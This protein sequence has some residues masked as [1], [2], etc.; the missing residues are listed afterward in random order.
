MEIND[1]A[2][3]I[4]KISIRNDNRESIS[5]WV[6]F[7]IHLDDVKDYET[8]RF[9]QEDGIF[10]SHQSFDGDYFVYMPNNLN[11]ITTIYAHYFIKDLYSYEEDTNIFFKYDLTDILDDETGNIIF[12]INEYD[13]YAEDGKLMVRSILN[14]SIDGY[15]NPNYKNYSEHKGFFPL[16][17]RFRPPY[18]NLVAPSFSDMRWRTESEINLSNNPTEVALI[19]DGST[20]HYDCYRRQKPLW[21]VKI[22]R[23]NLS[24]IISDTQAEE[25]GVPK[26]FPVNVY[27]NYNYLPTSTEWHQHYYGFEQGDITENNDFN[28]F[29]GT[30]INTINP[31]FGSNNNYRLISWGNPFDD[32]FGMFVNHKNNIPIDLSNDFIPTRCKW[33]RN[34]CDGYFIYKPKGAGK[35]TRHITLKEGAVYSLKYYMY[36]PAEVEVEDDS[37][38]ISINGIKIEKEFLK[39]DK[40]LRHQWIYHEVPFI[41]QTDNVIDIIGPQHDNEDDEIFFINLSIEE[42]P[43]YSPTLKYTG[44]GLFVVE[45]DQY[46]KKPINDIHDEC[47]GADWVDDEYREEPYELP[48]P[49]GKAFFS[50]DNEIEMRYDDITSNLTLYRLNTAEFYAYYS[51][52]DLFAWNEDATLSYDE[53]FNI[54]MEYN[55]KETLI[56]G[57][58]NSITL[59]ARDIYGHPI[60]SGEVEC[61]IFRNK[62]MGDVSGALVYVGK[63]PV[64]NGRIYFGHIN[65]K[66]I[67]VDGVGKFYLRIQYTN[68]CY[69]KDIIEFK[70]IYIESEIVNM[71]INGQTDIQNIILTSVDDL[72]LKI[73]A[74]ILNQI[75]GSISNGYCEL[76]IDDK[77][78]Q[79]TMV[80]ADGYADFYLDL[81]EITDINQTIKIT[82]YNR[83]YEAI[84]V[85]IFDLIKGTTFDI[86]PAIPIQLFAWEE[87]EMFIIH[88]NEYKA[89]ITDCIL[90]DIDTDINRENEQYINFRLEVYRHNSPTF[91]R[92]TAEQLFAENIL[93]YPDDSIAIFDGVYDGITVP[94]N[95]ITKY[96]TIITKDME[97]N[98]NEIRDDYRTYQRTIKVRYEV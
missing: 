21:E 85:V 64:Q 74:R 2:H 78:M 40:I 55:H 22:H 73:Q 10:L 92:E 97:N 66:D 72:P 42:F 19:S 44:R 54:N 33:E 43:E 90:I 41:G 39:Q 96:Y 32:R 26:Y 16:S 60:V 36:I 84:K 5:E 71:T 12:D 93:N 14:R 57:S 17:S 69:N 91:N 50:F 77:V 47:I 7:K 98:G 70:P 62:D 83:F 67:E 1:Y 28:V 45:E 75:G 87:D 94:S 6:T 34:K 80:D 31:Q 82:Y 9:S 18:Q 15:K 38:Y 35:C 29:E 27:L 49:I 86:K 61:A 59:K 20:P 51:S 24:A 95:P 79:A 65:L 56:R 53:D 81:D 30:D 48:I 11:T 58:N 68:K 23:D 13:M 3:K 63:K 46:A 52:E 8:I 76:S 89:P 4:K 37:C 88:K 25:D